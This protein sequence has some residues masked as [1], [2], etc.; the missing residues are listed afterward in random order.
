[1]KAT[2]MSLAL[3]MASCKD[4]LPCLRGHIATKVYPAWVQMMYMPMGKTFMMMPIY[5]PQ[6]TRQVFVCDEYYKGKYNE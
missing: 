6:E 5:H 1:M 2:L 3:L 4:D